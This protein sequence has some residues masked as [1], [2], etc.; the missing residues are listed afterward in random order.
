MKGA[1]RSKMMMII[2]IIIIP[3]RII[4]IIIIIIINNINKNN[5][6][7]SN[8]PSL[9]LAISQEVVS[10]L[11]V[12]QVCR[13]PKTQTCWVYPGL[14]K[15]QN[16]ATKEKFGPV[17]MAPAEIAGWSVV[18][19]GHPMET[20]QWSLLISCAQEIPIRKNHLKHFMAVIKGVGEK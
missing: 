12:E 19:A 15:Y 16:T 1:Q 10:F 11:V 18:F 7:S 8:L 14:T 20:K 9:P 13:A 17:E 5:L 3:I 6:T 4:I 2:I